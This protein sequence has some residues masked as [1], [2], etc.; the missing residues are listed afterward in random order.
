[1]YISQASRCCDNSCSSAMSRA[2][3][4]PSLYLTPQ[5]YASPGAIAILVSPMVVN[6]AGVENVV[7]IILTE[8]EY[9][10]DDNVF[11]SKYFLVLADVPA[12]FN[13]ENNG[14]FAKA[15]AKTSDLRANFIDFQNYLI[16]LNES[17]HKISLAVDQIHSQHFSWTQLLNALFER[18]FTD[19]KEGYKP[20]LYFEKKLPGGGDR[21]KG[22][23]QQLGL[24]AVNNVNEANIAF[25]VFDSLREWE[26]EALAA[27]VLLLPTN[28][29]LSTKEDRLLK[30]GVVPIVFCDLDSR[31]NGAQIRLVIEDGLDAVVFLDRNSVKT[32]APDL[33]PV[34]TVVNNLEVAI[35]KLVD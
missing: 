12:D 21:W 34:E 14:S 30:S 7:V 4:P 17:M 16:E 35:A 8:E 9:N 22:V 1:M 26:N 6:P 20:I 2:P 23:A 32:K 28:K 13:K 3:L 11:T 18:K 33:E 10:R 27:I 29:D 15:Y 19:P 24:Q 31:A 25:G 5:C